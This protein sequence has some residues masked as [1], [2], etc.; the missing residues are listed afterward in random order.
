MALNPLVSLS[1]RL[2][3]RSGGNRQTDRQMDRLTDQST[4]PRCACAPRVSLGGVSCAYIHDKYACAYTR[5]AR[6]REVQIRMQYRN[7]CCKDTQEGS[8]CPGISGTV[9]DFSKL[10]LVPEGVTTGPGSRLD[11]DQS[12]GAAPRSRIRKR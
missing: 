4:D 10:S 9:P 6:T 3:A 8:N 11:S 12:A 5:N 7:A 2:V 1:G